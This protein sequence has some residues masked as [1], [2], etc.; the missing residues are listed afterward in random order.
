MNSAVCVV[1]LPNCGFKTC[2]KELFGSYCWSWEA[3]KHFC[4]VSNN[5]AGRE[6]WSWGE[7]CRWSEQ[8][9]S[10]KIVCDRKFFHF[11]VKEVKKVKKNCVWPRP[12]R[13][14]STVIYGAVFDWCRICTTLP[15]LH[16]AYS[17]PGCAV[18][19]EPVLKQD[20]CR[21][22][23]FPLLELN[24][25]REEQVREVL[26]TSNIKN[27]LKPDRRALY[28]NF[29][30]NMI[31]ITNWLLANSLVL[32]WPCWCTTKLLPTHHHHPAPSR[33]NFTQQGMRV[34][35]HHKAAV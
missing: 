5:N 25:R 9:F 24:G 10:E 7:Q 22:W 17:A 34:S 20:I 18:I 28:V 16:W 1:L 33:K 4:V 2:C 8:Q 21:S 30:H 19:L 32:D 31:R 11:R 15:Q 29:A 14:L 27:L 13:Q 35:L 3:R 23:L 12:K 26:D 6:Q